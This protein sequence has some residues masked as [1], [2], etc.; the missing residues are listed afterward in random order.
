MVI[1]VPS[2]EWRKTLMSGGWWCVEWRYTYP[3]GHP[4]DTW[5]KTGHVASED[6]ADALIELGE[7]GMI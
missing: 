2:R 3:E 5:H 4:Q 6:I 7:A 1:V